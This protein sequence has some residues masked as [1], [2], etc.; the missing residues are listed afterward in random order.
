[1]AG[2]LGVVPGLRRQFGQGAGDLLQRTGRFGGALGE[3]LA[4]VGNLGGA[5]CDL[6][7]AALQAAEDAMETAGHLP[8]GLAEV[9]LV[10]GQFHV[11]GQVSF[12]DRGGQANP[13]A[14]VFGHGFDR[15]LQAAQ[16]AA[17]ISL[18]RCAEISL[19]DLP[20]EGFDFL[21]RPDHAAD[22]KKRQRQQ[23]QKQG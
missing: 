17:E 10:R 13:F 23:R 9:V 21:D 5:G 11:S 20:G 4:G 16:F 22:E 7:A 6:F 15:L 3:R 19:A 2:V 14:K 1:M 12:G 18:N 8:Q